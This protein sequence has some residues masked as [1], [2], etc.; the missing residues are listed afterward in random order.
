MCRGEGEKDADNGKERLGLTTTTKEERMSGIDWMDTS[1]FEYHPRP[2][3]EVGEDGR[4]TGRI[5]R[6][7]GDGMAQDLMWGVSLDLERTY[8][9]LLAPEDKDRF[10][11]TYEVPVIRNGKRGYELFEKLTLR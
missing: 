3:G 2:R 4:T 6:P 1:L 11:N 9:D 5:V 8:N 10:D 7:H